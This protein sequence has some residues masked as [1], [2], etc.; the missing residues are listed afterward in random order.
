MDQ[1]LVALRRHLHRHPEVS[2]RE[3]KTAAYILDYVG[4]HCPADEIVRLG[5]HGIAF[6]YNGRAPGK[7][8]LVRTELDALPI[9]EIND[10]EHKSIHDGVSHKCGHDG[11][12]AMVTGVAKTIAAQRP[13]RGRVVLLYQPAEETG[14]G[15]RTVFEDKNFAKVKPDIAFSLHNIPGEKMHRI[16]CKDGSFSRA[17]KSMIIRLEGKTA[18]ASK[19][20]TGV[21]PGRAAAEI[22]QA[23]ESINKGAA[24]GS[25]ITLIHVTVGEKAY[26][27]SAGYGEVHFTL[28]GL[29]NAALDTIWTQLEERAREIAGREKLGVSFGF[30][31]EFMA[32]TNAPE[33]A[34]MVRKA[35]NDLGYDYAEMSQ[36]N[37]WGEDFGLIISNVPGA[38]FG[39]GAGENS[40]DLHNPD[41]DFPDE[42]IETGQAMFVNLIR[43]ALA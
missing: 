33:A 19:P 26:G 18:H 12:M 5:G 27:V 25:L 36:P 23:A 17:V 35:A 30:T 41:Y 7:T 24:T 39:L 13:D 34:A 21:N 29:D 38:M 3:E 11:H 6:V 43:R 37:P 8:V 42:L 14:Q 22:V 31:E 4:A 28:R 2:G 1:D 20:E 15:A 32:N 9:Q 40:P 10:F 16:L